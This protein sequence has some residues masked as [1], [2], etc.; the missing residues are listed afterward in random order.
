VTADDG[1]AARARS[2][3]RAAQDYVTGRP[4]YPPEAVAWLVGDGRRVADVGAGTGKLTTALLGDGRTVVAVDP[5]EAMLDTLRREVPG[6]ETRP[7]T[8][9]SLPLE[10]GAFDALV[11]G[12]TWHWV[13]PPA[14]SREAGRVLRPGG[15]LGLIWNIRD[16]RTGWVERLGATM[17][18]SDAERL[19]AAGGPTVAA[20]FGA[21]EL[22]EFPWS[23]A[24]TPDEVVA[25]AAS[26]SYVIALP[27]LDR[28]RLLDAVRELLATHPQTAGR[29]TVDLPYITYAYRAVRP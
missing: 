19:I 23:R 9:E 13:D 14:A 3:G 18:G 25:M 2:F 15:V 7:G 11:F 6:V 4:G 17:H 28:A 5:D 26:R 22:Q 24:M 21:L 29:D 16:D 20:P 1:A 12:Q 27:D 8:A 10:D